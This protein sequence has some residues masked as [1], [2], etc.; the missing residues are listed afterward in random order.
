MV[1]LAEHIETARTVAGHTG[2]VVSAAPAWLAAQG[3]QPWMGPRSLPLWLPL[4]EYAG[5]GA[6][7]TSAARLP[8]RPL[9]ETLADTLAWELAQ[10]V[11]RERRAGLTDDQE[12]ELL[13]LLD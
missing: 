10:P 4:P 1:P 7:D 2:P 5:F 9:S 3:V 13:A 8:T 12:R 11:G 6:R